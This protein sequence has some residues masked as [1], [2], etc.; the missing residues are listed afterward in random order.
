MDHLGELPGTR[1]QHKTQARYPHFFHWFYTHRIGE[2]LAT[3]F[4]VLQKVLKF[5][6]FP[7]L[8][9]CP[10]NE[11]LRWPSLF[12]IIV[13]HPGTLSQQHPIKVSLFLART[14]AR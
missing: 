8:V 6:C 7:D 12:A 11:S 13:A 10:P 14:I 1:G 5:P 9:D 3:I 4:P 2:F